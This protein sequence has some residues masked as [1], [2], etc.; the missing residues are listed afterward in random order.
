MNH[1]SYTPDE[2]TLMA[3]FYNELEGAELK[4]VEAYLEQNPEAKAELEGMRTTQGMLGMLND[5]EAGEPLVLMD[6]NSAPVVAMPV[7]T[8]PKARLITIGFARTMIGVAAAIVLVFLM[9]ALTNLKVKS[10]AAGFA[11]SFGEEA[12]PA[13]V[14]KKTPPTIVNQGIDRQEVE[15]LL[16]AYMA[17]YGDSL[18]Q[19]LG[20]LERKIVSQNQR[21][22][23]LPQ[24]KNVL[25]SNRSFTIT[26]VQIMLNNLKKN[27]LNGRVD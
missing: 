4:Q 27:N 14:A 6:E 17:S 5:Q 24:Q 10:G 13:T 7:A 21:L 26:E 1:K 11:I 20:G 9:G 8:P 2:A 19:K 3:Y 22:T 18:S 25:A 15:K 16:S 12:P 23:K